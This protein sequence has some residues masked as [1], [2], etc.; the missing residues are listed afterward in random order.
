MRNNNIAVKSF[1]CV[2]NAQDNA[3]NRMFFELGA[4]SFK[5]FFADLVRMKTTSLTLTKEV[6]LE[7]KR[8]EVVVEG[9]HQR[10]QHGLNQIE[11]LKQIK[12]ALTANQQQMNANQ[13]FNFQ[14]EFQVQEAVDISGSGNY[15][16]NCQN[17]KWTCHYPC[18]YANDA[19]RKSCLA[20]DPNGFCRVCPGKCTWKQHF[21]QKFKYEWVKRK[22]DQSSDEIRKQYEDAQR[23]KLSNQELIDQ[24]KRQLQ[25]CKRDIAGLVN[26]TYHGAG[27]FRQ[28]RQGQHQPVAHLRRQPTAAGFGRHPPSQDSVFHERFRTA[29]FPQVQ[30]FRFLRCQDEK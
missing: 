3:F 2:C 28:R 4:H 27:H 15:V 5:Q 29:S 1:F 18:K 26:A 11:E 13:N 23:K 20:M 12:K 22:V 25:I 14:V 7:R 19:D 9:L 16:T 21:N 10:I 30:Q 8:L 24:L 17:C 6:L